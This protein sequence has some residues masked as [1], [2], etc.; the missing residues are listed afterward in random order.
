MLFSTTWRSRTSIK[1]LCRIAGV[2]ET[3]Q[4]PKIYGKV[5]FDI[6]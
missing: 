2:I 3:I 5:N 6:Y 4:G 1:F